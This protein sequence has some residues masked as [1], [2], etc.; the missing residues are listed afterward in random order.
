[1]E[2]F[3]LEVVEQIFHTYAMFFDWE[4]WGQVLTDPISWGLI[5]SLVLIEGL[6]SADNA[7]VLAVLVKHLPEKQRKKA[8]MY[9][10]FGAYFFRFVFIGIG[11]YL[12]KFWFIKVL[13]A[14]YLGWIVYSHF[15][16]KNEDEVE[17]TKLK[18]DSWLVRVFGTFWATVISVELMDLA[19]SVDSIL[20]ALAISDEIWILLIGGMLGILMMRTVAGLFL[21]LIERVP[22]LETTAFILIGIISAKMFLSVFGYELSHYVFFAILIIAFVITFIIHFINKKKQSHIEVVTHKK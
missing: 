3:K 1:M 9:G 17:A 8:L 2:V 12:I 20:A 7:L 13:G 19:F 6:L 10:M 22:E 21:T 18:K 14:A 15:R 5:G 11:V 16:S 4:M